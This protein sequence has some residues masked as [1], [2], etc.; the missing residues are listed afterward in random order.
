MISSDLAASLPREA[1][2]DL[3][4]AEAVPK[5]AVIVKEKAPASSDGPRKVKRRIIVDLRRFGVNSRMKLH[6]RIAL[7]C[8]SDYADERSGDPETPLLIS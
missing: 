4:P 5:M 3:F 7:P 6:E 1:A 8:I 2:L